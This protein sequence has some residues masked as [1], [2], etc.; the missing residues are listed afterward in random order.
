MNNIFN[1]EGKFVSTVNKIIDAFILGVCWLLCS[2]PVF[3]VGAAS[4]AFYYAFHKCAR[5]GTGGPFKE[6]F[7][8]FKANFKQG[9]VVWLIVALL[10]L[11][12]SLDLYI[13]L[14][15][16]L[17]IGNLGSFLV[18]TSF[19]ILA[20]TAMWGLCAF[21]YLSRFECTTADAVK[22][23]FIITLANLHWALLLLAVFVLAVVAFF[24][25]PVLSLFVP[26]IYMFLANRILEP[27]LRKYMRPEDLQ[28]QQ[29]LESQA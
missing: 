24:C 11:V 9:T 4:A 18:V 15:G 13:L 23:S 27:V 5:Q 14:S 6:F 22:N 28:E 26:A 8:G 29:E 7:R 10:L 16:A 3:T 20:I 21:A 2:I 17:Q 25:V 19:L 1:Y 12:L